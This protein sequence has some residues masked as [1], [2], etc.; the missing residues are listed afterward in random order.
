MS[1]FFIK[2]AQ[3][4][5]FKDIANNARER[6]HCYW[7]I[8]LVICD[9]NNGKAPSVEGIN[10]S[11]ILEKE[12]QVV[13]LDLKNVCDGFFILNYSGRS[14][15]TIGA[16]LARLIQFKLCFYFYCCNWIVLII[17]TYFDDYDIFSLNRNL[18]KKEFFQFL[19]KNEK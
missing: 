1:Y 8:I 14:T 13:G 7:G 19:V 5:T 12:T 6:G 4:L 3:G 16:Y 18:T 15:T 11:S 10:L 9:P 17:E 2:L